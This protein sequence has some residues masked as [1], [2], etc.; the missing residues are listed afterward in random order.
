VILY[1]TDGQ[2]VY[3]NRKAREIFG[4]AK[5]G[6]ERGHDTTAELE[7]GEAEARIRETAVIPLLNSCSGWSADHPEKQF[8][9]RLPPD[10]SLPAVP[11]G[12]A[13]DLTE[14]PLPT[15]AEAPE[16]LNT[17]EKRQSPSHREDRGERRHSPLN[18][19]LRVKPV[20]DRFD[21]PLGV[22]VFGTVLPSFAELLDSYR[23]TDREAEVLDYLLAGWTIRKTARTLCITERTVKAHITSI[24]EKTGAANRVELANLLTSGRSVPGP[25]SN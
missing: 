6:T 5:I 2:R 15:A 7:R 8:T 24:Y 17:Q 13:V 4:E 22:L 21:D 10:G 14:E 23:L 20:L 12:S 11:L 25:E 9:L 16:E 19:K 18:L 1:D 3:G